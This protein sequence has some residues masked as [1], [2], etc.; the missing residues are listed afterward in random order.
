[1][2]SER[3]GYQEVRVKPVGQRNS[4]RWLVGWS[5]R[6]QWRINGREMQVS[7]MVI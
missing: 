5:L 1:M 6:T 7:M 2:W 4:V 3:E